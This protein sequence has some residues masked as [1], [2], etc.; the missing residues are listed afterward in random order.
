MNLR[1]GNTR[2]QPLAPT[3]PLPSTSA[4]SEAL[5]KTCGISLASLSLSVFLSLSLA[6]L[7]QQQCNATAEI[8]TTVLHD[9]RL[10]AFAIDDFSKPQSAVSVPLCLSSSV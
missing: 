9:S 7:A 6:L 8:F 1:T 10:L 3:L 5:I 2:L 4:L